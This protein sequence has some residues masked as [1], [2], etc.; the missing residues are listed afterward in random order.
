MALFVDVLSCP[1][2][3]GRC[4]RI[5]CILSPSEL[6][7]SLFCAFKSSYTKI[8]LPP[9]YLPPPLSGWTLESGRMEVHGEGSIGPCTLH[10]NSEQSTAL[11]RAFLPPCKPHSI[12][13]SVHYCPGN[14]CLAYLSLALFFLTF[15]SQ[16]F[17]WNITKRD[18]GGGVTSTI[19]HMLHRAR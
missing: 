11:L 17:L 13:L 5:S 14:P 7:F 8:N 2:A 1:G 12:Q 3:L 19:C 16:L 18:R 10:L 6:A 15:S 9:L 4:P